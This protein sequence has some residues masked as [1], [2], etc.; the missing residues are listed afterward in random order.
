[1][2]IVSLSVVTK[3]TT[4]I[5]MMIWLS[6]ENKASYLDSNDQVFSKSSGYDR[7]ANISEKAQ[8]SRQQWRGYNTKP[9]A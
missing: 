3:G 1:M 7:E 2:S 6:R 8:W 5:D 4:F 9:A